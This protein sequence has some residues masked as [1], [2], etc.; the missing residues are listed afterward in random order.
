M[1]VG[2]VAALCLAVAPS[3]P[4]PAAAPI[5]PAEAPVEA[6]AAWLKSEP[7]AL[8]GLVEGARVVGLGEG[9]HG[10]HEF[11][12]WKRAAIEELVL[13]G[14]CRQVAFEIGFAEAAALDG[15]VRGGPGDPVDLV[16]ANAF[17]IYDTIEFVG[18][19]R[20]LRSRNAQQPVEGQVRLRGIDCQSSFAAAEALA[21]FLAQ[22]DP[23]DAPRVRK[24]LAPLSAGSVAALSAE[25]RLALRAALGDLETQFDELEEKYVASSDEAGFAFARQLVVVLRQ[26]EAQATGAAAAVG[27]RASPPTGNPRDE[28]MA[29]NVAFWV[30]QAPPD[31]ITVVWAHNGHVSVASDRG[32]Q[33]WM[34]SWLRERFGSSYR[35]IGS[36]FGSGTFQALDGM[37]LD[38]SSGLQEFR[39]GPP[40][41]DSVEAP[42]HATGAERLLVDLRRPAPA[43]VAEWL[44]APHPM[45][46]IGGAF[47][48]RVVNGFDLGEWGAE[49]APRASFD[50]L[51]F[52]REA[53]RAVPNR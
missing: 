1:S 21:R 52:V 22:V 49:E 24:L 23:D 3:E 53:T 18:L 50:A 36:C 42:F 43:D 30:E 8:S 2:A 28:A 25:R 6:V 32:G 10:T 14:D 40:R 7:A 46:V 17:S 48:E 41:P 9:T 47:A 29:A 31:S 35:A 12:E 27:A 4:L 20:W 5:A 13:R 15:W 39:V 44:D 26:F 19:L 34:G 38:G 51:W 45:R 37:R 11:F 16:R 33:R